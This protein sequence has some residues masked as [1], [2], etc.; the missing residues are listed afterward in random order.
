MW[1]LHRIATIE[2]DTLRARASPPGG[3]APPAGKDRE[4]DSMDVLF[5]GK[6][7]D[8]RP[9]LAAAIFNHLAPGH[10]RAR[11]LACSR[12]EPPSPAALALL[13]RQGI[14]PGPTAGETPGTAPRAGD[15]VI[16]LCSMHADQ[17]CLHHAETPPHAHWAV[18]DPL[19]RQL[20]PHR[21]DGGL[22]D[23]YHILRARIERL[24]PLLQPGS[25]RDRERLENE[26]ERIGRFLP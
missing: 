4:S 6:G 21:E 17:A 13:A 18:H 5:V 20:F 22:L 2:A 12:D 26:L 7:G 25:A 1:K 19:Q 8:C 10:C 23:V 14:R 3:E 15:V 24:L 9:L 16:S 11:R